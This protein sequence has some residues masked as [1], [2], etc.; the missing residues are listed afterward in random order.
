MTQ[1][2]T[3]AQGTSPRG[4]FIGAA[5]LDIQYLFDDLPARNTK[6]P[7][8]DLAVSAG[9]PAAN[10]AALFTRLGGTSGLVAAIG[11]HPVGLLIK[12]DL[13]TDE[14][15]IVDLARDDR[16]PRVSAIVTTAD[17]GD[18]TAMTAPRVS[19]PLTLARMREAD[20][21]GIDIMLVDGMLL[22]A[23]VPLAHEARRYDKPVILDS[24]SWKEGL[25]TL[26]PHI[27][28]AIV[29]ETFRTPTASEP[30]AILQE[31]REHGIPYAAMT[32][33]AD[34]IRILTDKGFGEVPVQRVSPV[35]DTLGAGDFFHGAFCLGFAKGL[36][37]EEA[38][39]Y[40][41]CI[42]GD[43]VQVF[44]SRQWLRH[45]PQ[46]VCDLRAKEAS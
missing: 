35:V 41:S 7:A 17:D 19:R 27:S 4:L 31:L 9:G 10:A 20:V 5:T 38:M 45:V 33:G 18:R 44:G 46:D 11:N 25:E 37:F 15:F 24:G 23:A 34:P 29:G 14:V 12:E 1:K 32:R 30:D 42:V 36:S 40:A 8:Q 22:E 39:R 6:R 13:R 3:P 43:R 21:S 2:K 16:L 26:L 28:H